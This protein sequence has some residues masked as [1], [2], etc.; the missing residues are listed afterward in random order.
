MSNDANPPAKAP[1]AA[2]H[3]LIQRGVYKRNLA[4]TA[5]FLG[6]RLAEPILQYALLRHNLGAPLMHLFGQATLPPG[7]PNTGIVRLDALGLSPYRL[8]LFGMAA[9]QA[10][11][12]MLWQAWLR[13]EDFP[14][15]TAIFVASF[16]AVINAVNVLLFTGAATSA[17]LSAGAVFPQ[18]PLL[19]GLGLFTVGITVELGSEVQRW[20]F[21]KDAKN[22]G[23]ACTT[24][25]WALLR[26]PN[27]A[28]YTLW[29][30]G[31]A[32]ASA[33]WTW[34][35]ITFGFFC[36]DFM[37]RGVPSLEAYCQTRVGCNQWYGDGLTR[38]STE[39][40]GT[41]TRRRRRT[42]FCPVY[43]RCSLGPGFT[44][45]WSYGKPRLKCRA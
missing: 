41:N 24:G 34:G 28:G 10:A 5:V 15:S 13:A 32:V 18:P 26:H 35:A 6:L 33:G 1:S 38:R 23:K 45:A 44:E 3:D 43:F 21:K 40:S 14:P 30:T 4:G 20:A 27:Y 39:P 16:N 22:E 9:V 19:V 31:M 29:R 8:A 2:P 12:Q 37:T 36:F 42:T 7:P 17:S 25:L 11:K